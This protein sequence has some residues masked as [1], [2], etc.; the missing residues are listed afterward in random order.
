[1]VHHGNLKRDEDYEDPSPLP[2]FVCM[3]T[4]SE[5]YLDSTPDND[6][7][8]DIEIGWKDF[9]PEERQGIV[10]SLPPDV[11]M[12]YAD[13]SWSRDIL[14][15]SIT[16]RDSQDF[17]ISSVVTASTTGNSQ[18]GGEKTSKL[19][20]LNSLSS[21]SKCLPKPSDDCQPK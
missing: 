19:N 15:K 16:E 2:D 9:T 5:L 1:M 17:R 4:D 8:P 10:D 13:N 7:P 14:R 20:N 18:H 11:D 12:S 21:Y 6:I 3:F